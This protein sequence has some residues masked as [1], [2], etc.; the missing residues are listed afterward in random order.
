MF[1]V[2]DEGA[3]AVGDY[4]IAASDPDGLETVVYHAGSTYVPGVSTVRIKAVASSVDAQRGTVFLGPTAIDY[5]AILSNDPAMVPQVDQVFDAAGIQPV[6]QGLVIAG[7]SDSSTV[8]C[9]VLD[10]RM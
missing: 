6:S 8:G 10:G 5:T 3:F 1:E 2:R 7:P 4:V 9:S